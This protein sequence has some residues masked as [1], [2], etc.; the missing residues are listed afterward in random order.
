M[1]LIFKSRIF[2]R[3][4][5]H[6]YFNNITSEG[7]DRILNLTERFWACKRNSKYIRVFINFS[8]TLLENPKSDILLVK[9]KIENDN[10]EYKLG[11]HSI[12]LPVKLF[13]SNI[14]NYIY[15]NNINV[16]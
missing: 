7:F 1:D 10:V 12:L 6:W 5:N 9:N 3:I 13:I 14:P 4:N 11:K 8:N 16:L 2:K 15:I